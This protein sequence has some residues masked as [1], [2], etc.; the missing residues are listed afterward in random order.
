MKKSKV[1]VITD[2][3]ML[4]FSFIF[5]ILSVLSHKY[6][7]NFRYYTNILL[8]KDAYPVK[9]I[10]ITRFNCRQD[11]E[12]F[13]NELYY[14]NVGGCY[15]PTLK[16]LFDKN[17]TD[18]SI[19]FIED[20]RSIPRIAETPLYIWRDTNICIKRYKLDN[21]S[22]Y[23]YVPN[24]K[25][26]PQ[27]YRKCGKIDAFNNLCMLNDIDC[28]ITDIIFRDINSKDPIPDGYEQ[29]A[30]NDETTILLYTRQPQL[31]KSIPIDFRISQNIP[32][33]D[34]TMVSNITNIFPLQKQQEK[35]G[36]KVI[37]PSNKTEVEYQY[38]ERYDVLDSY[39]L[40]KYY[41]QNE[42]NDINSFPNLPTWKKD[43]NAVINLYKRTGVNINYEC[44]DIDSRSSFNRSDRTLKIVGFKMI[45]YSLA[46]L[47]ILCIFLSIINIIKVNNK[48]QNS[49]LNFFKLSFLALFIVLLFLDMDELNKLGKEMS[50]VLEVMKLEKCLDEITSSIYFKMMH[51]DKYLEYW[52]NTVSTITILNYIYIGVFIIQFFKFVHKTYLRIRNLRRNKES[53]NILQQALNINKI[54]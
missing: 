17:C 2:V 19:S 11:Y 38:D 29:L 9:S 20:R 31:D 12:H 50:R 7:T 42:L 26:C 39:Q 45:I 37:N 13:S 10:E 8:I 49:L 44:M 52:N 22:M 14:G 28:P 33:I 43:K 48:I 25:E 15:L 32:C 47:F 5:V 41:E 6:L 46:N 53:Q 21:D 4:I 30:L 23:D 34:S 51:I 3:F 36:C 35:Y 24:T 54:N 16:L 18:D 27:N 40:R 1:T